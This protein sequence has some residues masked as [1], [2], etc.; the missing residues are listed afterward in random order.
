VPGQFTKLTQNLTLHI[1]QRETNGQLLGVFIDDQRDEK[2]RT[3]LLAERGNVVRTERGTFL[4][5]ANGSAQRHQAGRRD[6]TI[7]LFDSYGFD[8]SELVPG[9]R[10]IKYSTRERYLWELINPVPHDPLFNDVPGQVRAELHDR[11]TAPF[12]PLAFVFVTF[13]YL[14]A[15]R[16]TRQ[17]RATSMFGAIGVIALVRALGFVGMVLGIN[18]PAALAIPYLALGSSILLGYLAISRGIIIEPPAFIANAINA[19]TERIARRTEGATG[20]PA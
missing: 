9:Q 3:T 7:V 8:L 5:L 15:P 12:Y 19:I 11:L 4:V 17:S 6:P 16:T 1:R 13:A 18:S 20:Q 10:D 2:E 14:G